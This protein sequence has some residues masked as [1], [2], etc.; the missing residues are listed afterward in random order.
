MNFGKLSDA[1]QRMRRN[2]LFFCGVWIFINYFDVTSVKFSVIEFRT[3]DIVDLGSALTGT[4]DPA[5][6]TLSVLIACLGSFA[7]LELAD[8]IRATGKRSQKFTWLVAGAVAKG[9]GVW[10]MHFI[11]MLAFSLPLKVGYDLLATLLSMVP[12]IFAGGMMLYILGRP[13][14]RKRELIAGGIFM[15]AGIGVMHYTGMAAMRMDAV[16]R[17]DPILFIVS[18]VVAIMLAIGAL[19]VKYLASDRNTGAFLDRTK[20]GSTLVMGLAV[21]CMHYT[22]MVAVEFFPT[23]AS[24]AEVVTLNTWYLAVSVGLVTAVII[25]L[26]N[27]ASRVGRRLEVVYLLEREI[28]ERKK[29]EEALQE[30]EELF[31]DISE[32]AT[33]RFWE[34]DETLRFTS[35]FDHP[36]LGVFPPVEQ[37]I[38]R[39]RWEDGRGGPGQGREMGQASRRPS[40][41]PSFP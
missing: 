41:P 23:E 26:V 17:Y 15:G 31:R 30:T 34:M 24:R 7:T 37:F 18:I 1:T 19:Y 32:A 4:Y 8:R 21:A 3:D 10:A 22:A 25:M 14:L 13:K 40:G 9:S 11:A 35:M 33:D 29:A 12:A 20:I 2:L 27:V 38:G 5:L 39:T 28:A 6:V 16:M 36:G